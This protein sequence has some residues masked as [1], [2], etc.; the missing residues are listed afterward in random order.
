[1]FMKE[2]IE[3]SYPIHIQEN[4]KCSEKDVGCKASSHTFKHYFFQISDLRQQS[5]IETPA[6]DT[7]LREIRLTR[8]VMCTIEDHWSTAGLSWQDLI[9]KLLYDIKLVDVVVCNLYPFRSTVAA[10]D[11]TVEKAIENIDI[12]GVT[13]LRAAAKNYARVCVLCDPRDYEKT[14]DQVGRKW[15]ENKSQKKTLTAGGR[16]GME[17]DFTKRSFLY[18]TNDS[19]LNI[20]SGPTI[21]RGGVDIVARRLLA[22]KKRTP[23]GSLLRSFALCTMD[24]VVI[25]CDHRLHRNFNSSVFSKSMLFIFPN[26]P[27]NNLPTPKKMLRKQTKQVALVSLIM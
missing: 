19:V 27:G 5:K 22:L 17:N 12:G 15:P 6:V 20:T 21:K 13:L 1:M 18:F 10:S 23:A 11:C 25:E 26:F 24:L 4:R 14:L 2:Q 7:K 3:M 8:Q 9:L 16:D